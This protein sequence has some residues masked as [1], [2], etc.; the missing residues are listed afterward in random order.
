MPVLSYI[1]ECKSS[2]SDIQFT[3]YTFWVIL[4]SHYCDVHITCE[5]LKW[6]FICWYMSRIE[7]HIREMLF[8]KLVAAAN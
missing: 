2:E 4:N 8:N 5:I 1:V 3:L 7:C 6:P